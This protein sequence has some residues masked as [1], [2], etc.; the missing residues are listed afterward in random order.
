MSKIK[1]VIYVPFDKVHISFTLIHSETKT[2][3]K[4]TF[5]IQIKKNN[6]F[7]KIPK[8]LWLQINTWYNRNVTLS[9]IRNNW[10]V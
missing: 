6:D 7:Y 4:W 3:K 1:N 10:K 8:N 2:F 9:H 5:E